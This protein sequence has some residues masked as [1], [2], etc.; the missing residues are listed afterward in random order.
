MV[1]KRMEGSLAGSVMIGIAVSSLMILLG[2]FCAAWLVHREAVEM[3]AIGYLVMGILFLSGIAGGV[4]AVM[5]AK[6]K[7]L[8]VG[9][10]I[11]VAGFLI[12]LCAGALFFD[13]SLNGVGQ[14]MLLLIGANIS[15]VLV[16]TH[17]KGRTKT[18]RR[19]IRTG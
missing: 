17:R 19:R 7:I 11:G 5:K 13:G 1:K 10:V 4:A 9:A 6:E 2:C 3:D 16:G 12:L 15:A 18:R 14:T 8:I